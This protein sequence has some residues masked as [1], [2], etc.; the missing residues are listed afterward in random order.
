M[1][2]SSVPGLAEGRETK[3]GR[4]EET[5]PLSRMIERG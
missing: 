1:G 5:E 2:K 4:R 3:E